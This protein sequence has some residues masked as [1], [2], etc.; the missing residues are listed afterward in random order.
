VLL[1]RY[2]LNNSS[3]ICVSISTPVLVGNFE[4]R[5]GCTSD[6]LVVKWTDCK[7]GKG[8][9]VVEVVVVW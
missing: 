8:G 9:S 2:G 1:L 3:R 7:V 4:Q 5:N 6:P